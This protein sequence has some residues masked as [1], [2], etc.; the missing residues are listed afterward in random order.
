[1]GMGTLVFRGNFVLRRIN[2][3]P[4]CFC[5][6]IKDEVAKLINLKKQLGGEPTTKK[7]TLKNPK[8]TRDY[9]PKQMAIREKVFKTI[10]DV[11]QKHGAVELATPVFELKETLTGKYGDD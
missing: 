3:F 5:S 4:R 10:I 11:F 8:G 2:Q 6:E 1:M 9:G 7:F